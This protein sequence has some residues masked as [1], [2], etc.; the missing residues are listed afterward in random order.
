MAL[1]ASAGRVVRQVVG[2]GLRLTIAGLAVGT[3]LA[4]AVSRTIQ[5]LL[6]GVSPTDPRTLAAAA[7]LFAAIAFT[8]SALPAFRAARVDPMNALREL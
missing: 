1:G 5:A 7:G 4:L 3:V 6:Y 8:A 2:Q